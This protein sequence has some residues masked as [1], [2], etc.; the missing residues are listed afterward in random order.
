MNNKGAV[1]R[2]LAPAPKK[3]NK[4]S[5]EPRPGAPPAVAPASP[6]TYDPFPLSLI[7]PSA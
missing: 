1:E 3:L 2:P 4:K 7:V 6:H 5:T